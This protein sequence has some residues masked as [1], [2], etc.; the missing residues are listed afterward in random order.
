MS[1]DVADQLPPELLLRL[2]PFVQE[3]IAL[4]PPALRGVLMRAMGGTSGE[5]TAHAHIVGTAVFVYVAVD[6]GEG[7][8]SVELPGYLVGLVVDGAEI[9]WRP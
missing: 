2:V 6:T 7:R 4:E 3:A 5:M 1:A 9:A 8:W